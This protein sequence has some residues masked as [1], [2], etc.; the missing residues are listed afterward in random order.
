M[1]DHKPKVT[2]EPAKVKRGPGWYVRISYEGG[3]TEVSGFRSEVEA[4]MWI[5]RESETWLRKYEGGRLA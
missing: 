1:A 2:L 5:Q 3:Q 4:K